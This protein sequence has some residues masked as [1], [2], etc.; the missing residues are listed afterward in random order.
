MKQVITIRVRARIGEGLR[1]IAPSP[2]FRKRHGVLGIFQRLFQRIEEQPNEREDEG[3]GKDNK[4]DGHHDEQ[5]FF[6]PMPLI[7]KVM[8]SF[9]AALAIFVPFLAKGSLGGM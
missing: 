6:T 7:Q 5:G 9:V 2:C 4:E 3:G 8:F 1:E